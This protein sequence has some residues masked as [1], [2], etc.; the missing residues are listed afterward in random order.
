M[1]VQEVK[2]Y[3]EDGLYLGGFSKLPMLD[4][5]WPDT[6]H[7]SSLCVTITSLE[8][9]ISCLGQK[10][11]NGVF[12]LY[13]TP[14]G[15]RAFCLSIE[16]S[17]ESFYGR[18]TQDLC[19]DPVYISLAIVREMFRFRLSPKQARLQQGRYD[20]IAMPLGTVV[21]GNAKVLQRQ[22]ELVETYHDAVIAKWWAKAPMHYK[23]GIA[24][25]VQQYQKL[26]PDSKKLIN[27]DCF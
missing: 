12:K 11:A 13:I 5:D 7:K 16:A 6:G 20:W 1:K 2:L 17:P 24:A 27:L 14:G 15:V 18:S 19:V 22:K 23:A 4:W 10:V 21:L 26:S 8:D 25:V 3:K 9:V